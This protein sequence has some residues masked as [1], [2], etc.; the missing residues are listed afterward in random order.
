MSRQHIQYR[1]GWGRRSKSNP[2]PLSKPSYFWSVDISFTDDV[3]GIP[4]LK[5]PMSIAAFRT[6]H[7]NSGE[8]YFYD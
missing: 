3:T 1:K 2:L 4:L 5:K 7:N 8:T 6:V